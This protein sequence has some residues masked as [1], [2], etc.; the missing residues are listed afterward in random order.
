MADMMALQLDGLTVG[1][2]EAMMVDTTVGH[3]AGRSALIVVDNLADWR[4]P[5]LV[6]WMDWKMVMRMADLSAGM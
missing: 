2:L 1:C 4:E 6:A 3:W 5:L